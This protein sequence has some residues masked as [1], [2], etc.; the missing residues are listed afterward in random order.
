MAGRGL[1]KTPDFGKR[2]R[3]PGGRGIDCG[4][5]SPAL[6]ARSVS[7][8]P[9][10]PGAELVGPSA[11]PGSLRGQK[12]RFKWGSIRRPPTAP[13]LGVS[14][15]GWADGRG[16]CHTSV[17]SPSVFH[18]LSERG[19]RQGVEDIIFGEPGSAGLQHAE[20]DLLQV[21]DVV[22]VGVDDDLHAMLLRLA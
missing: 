19:G 2:F 5:I 16:G 4:R 15:A 9:T 7:V 14:T 21:R 22:G 6:T 17:R 1:W 12:P 20:T 10:G 11:E 13:L 3:R 18:G 8:G